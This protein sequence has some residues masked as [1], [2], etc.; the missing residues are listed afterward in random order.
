MAAQLSSYGSSFGFDLDRFMKHMPKKQLHPY[1]PWGGGTL[2]AQLH[3]YHPQGAEVSSL[4]CHTI[5][6][7]T[8]TIAGHHFTSYS[9]TW[10]F[11]FSTLA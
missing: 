7:Y 9:F 10:Y 8:I 3:V 2:T 1:H 4:H 11:I 6:Y 5:P